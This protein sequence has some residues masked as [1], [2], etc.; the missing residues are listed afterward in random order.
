MMALFPYSP[1]QECEYAG[2]VSL[3]PRP[4]VHNNTRQRKTS[5]KQGRPRSIYHV[6]GREVGVGEGPI[7]KYV[8]TKFES[9]FLTNQD[10]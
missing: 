1:A 9:E 4:C 7:F 8:H 3:V 6:S 5:E 10:E 2:K